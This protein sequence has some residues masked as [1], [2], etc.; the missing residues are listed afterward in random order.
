MYELSMRHEWFFARIGVQ[1]LNT[2]APYLVGNVPTKG[3]HCAWMESSAVPL[4]NSLFGGRTNTEGCESTGAAM[5][6]G[7]IPYWG[8]HLDE[9]RLGTD[10]VS[11]EFDLATVMDWGLLGYY[12]GEIVQEKVPVLDGVMRIPNL[13][14]LQ[15]FAAAAASSGGVEM[16]HIAGITPEATSVEHAFG[17]KRAAASLKFGPA[18]RQEAYEKLNSSGKDSHV[19]FVVLG[20]PHYGIE[21]IWHVCRL[22]EGKRI[23]SDSSLWIFAPRAIKDMADRNGY[24]EIIRNSGA[25]LM[26]D[27]CP[28][29]GQVSP[30]GVRVAATDSAKQ[31]HYLPALLGFPTW[32][33]S[34][35]E[36]IRAAINGRWEGALT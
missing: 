8:Y 7:K 31:A 23:H 10:L 28:A 36:C 1:L 11:I 22:L 9:N 34:Q 14:R 35:E 21:E 26:T 17:N 4:C 27:N 16:F 29:L 30:K 20:C 2:C 6:T 3:Q 19:D 24:T 32:F 33:G 18:E 13:T 5:L 15:H 12:T 25:L